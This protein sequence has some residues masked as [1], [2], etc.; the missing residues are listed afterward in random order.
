MVLAGVVYGAK[1]FIFYSYMDV[2]RR[3][4]KYA[5]GSEKAEWPKS[6]S[7]KASCAKTVKL[8]SSMP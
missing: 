4:Q 7:I 1:G 6:L 3:I 5:P 2:F 8:P